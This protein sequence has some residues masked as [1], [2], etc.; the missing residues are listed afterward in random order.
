M[1]VISIGSDYLHRH[2][3]EEGEEIHDG[4]ARKQLSLQ[5]H[6]RVV[7]VAVLHRDVVLV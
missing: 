5:E 3:K 1:H 7:V 4:E 2:T 6:G